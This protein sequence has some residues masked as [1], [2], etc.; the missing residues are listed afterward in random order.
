MVKDQ[1]GSP[2]PHVVQVGWDTDLFRSGAGSDAIQ[3]QSLYLALMRERDPRARS[4]VIVLGA[5]ASAQP[6]SVAGVDVIPVQGRWRGVVGLGRVLE[7]VHRQ[8]AITRLA[9]QSLHEEGWATLAFGRR[10]GI[11][12]LGQLHFD[13][14]DANA[15]VTGSVLRRLVGRIRHRITLKLLP[16]YDAI[17]TVSPDMTAGALRA[18]ASTVRCLP[19]AVTDLLAFDVPRKDRGK[20]ILFLG[21]LVKFKN[22]PLFVEV[23]DLIRQS[24]PDVRA[25]IIGDGPMRGQIAEVIRSRGLDAVISM[26]GEVGRAALPA[27]LAGAS[28]LLSTSNHEGFGR[29]LIEAMIAGVPIVSTRTTGP[30]SVL[31]DGRWGHLAPVGDAAGL[32]RATVAILDDPPRAMARGSEAKAHALVRYAPETLAREWADMLIGYASK[33]GPER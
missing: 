20:I 5:P 26:I 3:R 4:T 12:V 23:I 22:V 6:M 8:R 28:A 33:T 32:A 13:I 25:E 7:A 19:V 1:Q 27:R 15:A 16:R 29:V 14:F 17:R 11:P 9:A 31:E 21:R 30:V 10:Y 24:H 18:G 2:P